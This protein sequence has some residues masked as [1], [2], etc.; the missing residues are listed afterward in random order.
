MVTDSFDWTWQSG[1]TPTTMTG[2]SA[3]HTGGNM[4]IPYYH[5][6]S[7][8]VNTDKQDWGIQMNSA[9]SILFRGRIYHFNVF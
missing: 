6:Y 3:D 4:I 7:Q 1:S 9:W 8:F 5:K 2:P